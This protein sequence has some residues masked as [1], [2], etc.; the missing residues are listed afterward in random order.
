MQLFITVGLTFSYA[1]GPYLTIKY[2]NILCL[3]FPALFL[4]LFFVFIPESPYYLLQVNKNKEA[5]ESLMKLRSSSGKAVKIELESIRRSVE[6]TKANKAGFTDIFAT[7]ST[8]K[9]FIISLSLVAFQQ[10]S[11]INVIIFYAQ[12][13]FKSAGSTLAPEISAILI[14]VV[15]ILSSGATPVLVERSGKRFLLLVS[16][17][18]MTLSL[19]V[20]AYYFYLLEKKE[21]VSNISL[22]PIVCLVVFIIV[23]CLGFGPLPWAVMGELFP[24]NIKSIA[25]TCTASFCWILGFI[26]TKYFNLLSDKIGQSGSFGF[27]SLCCLVAANFILLYL[28][29]TTG[30]SLQEI[31]LLLSK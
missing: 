19:A 11:G 21:D 16:A 30:K 15:Q 9:A 7:R 13:I 1:A 20:L 14:G 22:L 2:F 25:S 12:D 28:P 26:I 24:G 5:E 18:G 3:I 4:I 17:S 6:E 8:T 29:E 10:L 23:Y 27:F 31:Q